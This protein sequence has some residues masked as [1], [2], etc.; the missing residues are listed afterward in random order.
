MDVLGDILGLL[1]ANSLPLSRLDEEDLGDDVDNDT[2]N[3]ELDEE[4]R[5]MVEEEG[6]VM[7]YSNKSSLLL[8]LW[9]NKREG[10]KGMMWKRIRMEKYKSI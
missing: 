4:L 1:H 3:L 2:D 5:S 8:D 6:E 9:D 7:T 10:K